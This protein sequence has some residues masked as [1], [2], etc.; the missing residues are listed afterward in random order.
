MAKLRQMIND[1]SKNLLNFDPIPFILDPEVKINGTS[2][3][4][5]AMFKV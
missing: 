3:D 5:T 2:A 4:N 1:A